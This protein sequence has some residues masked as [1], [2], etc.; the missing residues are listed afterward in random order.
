M[1]SIQQ[2]GLTLISCVSLFFFLLLL[3]LPISFLYLFYFFFIYV[4]LSA[5]FRLIINSIQ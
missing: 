2:N 1:H 3:L 4:R 5:S